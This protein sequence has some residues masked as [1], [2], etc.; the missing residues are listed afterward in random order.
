MA[1]LDSEQ[2]AS[3]LEQIPEWELEANKIYREFKFADFVGAFGFMGQVA[4]LAERMDHPPEW[5]NV[6]NRVQ[7]YLT[8][9]DDGGISARDI[10]LAQQIDSLL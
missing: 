7:V 5:S 3:A 2:L 1:L 10:S 8:S 9:H 6:Y 4:L